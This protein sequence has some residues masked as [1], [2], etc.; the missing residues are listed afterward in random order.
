MVVRWCAWPG[1]VLPR[2]W[3]WHHFKKFNCH[4]THFDLVGYVLLL[5]IL[6]SLEPDDFLNELFNKVHFWVMKH[7][8]RCQL[9]KTAVCMAMTGWKARALDWM[10]FRWASSVK[11]D[12][13]RT[14][15][16]INLQTY[17][18]SICPCSSQVGQRLQ[19]NICHP[20]L[21]LACTADVNDFC[22]VHSCILVSCEISIWLK[23]PMALLTNIN[24]HF[25]LFDLINWLAV[26]S[27]FVFKPKR[28]RRTWRQI[29]R[30]LYVVFPLPSS[31]K[32]FFP[33]CKKNASEKRKKILF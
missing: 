6:F 14:Q 16:S 27:H 1:S 10:P 26:N 28:D 15:P 33:F 11:E 7:Q 9:K 5:G 3:L 20:S 30:S 19:K 24:L 23:A 2:V 21:H 22:T 8:W 17:C 18:S 29:S 32:S 12:S 31:P 25:S 4:W 13:K